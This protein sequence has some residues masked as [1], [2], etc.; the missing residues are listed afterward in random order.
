MADP[1]FFPRAGT[2]TVAEIAALVQAPIPTGADAARVIRGASPIEYAGPSDIAYMDNP[3][4]AEAL[5]STRAAACFVAKRFAPRVP[6]TTIALVTPDP[7]RAFARVL[8]QMF[9]SAQRPGSSFEATCVAAAAL[10]HPE[11][12]LEDGVVVDPGSVVGPR[13]E[14]GHGTVIAAN[15]VIGPDVRIGRGCFI[16]PGSVVS[17]ALLG[18]GVIIHTGARIGQDGFG[19]AMGIQGHLKIPQIGRVIIQDDVEIGANT[20]IDRGAS[21]DTMIG[22]GTKIDNLVQI[23]HN[24]VIGRHC[25]IVAQVGISG[26]ATLEDFVVIG[27]Q[28]G[29]VGHVTI[30][31]GA[32]IAGSSNVASD[33]PPGVRWGGSPA[34]PLREWFREMQLVTNW[35][36]TGKRGGVPNDH[37]EG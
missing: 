18:N 26:S 36:R 31:Q 1:V 19:F 17:S 34:K 2:P 4:Y 33:V 27:G 6:T 32:Q 20:T 22:E 3:R 14:I 29:V 7:Y 25:V 8:G 11:A 15:A 10:V 24:V 5:A 9:P 35:A 37:A 13:A 16:G 12:R 28:V 30:G 23:G 21:R